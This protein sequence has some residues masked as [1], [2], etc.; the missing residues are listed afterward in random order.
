MKMKKNVQIFVI[1]NHKGGVGKSV[2]SFLAGHLFATDNHEKVRRYEHHRKGSRT[3]VIDLD[4]QANLS[5]AILKEQ[6]DAI[7][8]GVLEAIA[9]QDAKSYIVKSENHENLYVLPAT[10]ALAEFDDIFA[11][12]LADVPNPFHLLE[13]SLE[14]V[15]EEL[16]I[17]NIVIDTSPSL[18]KMMLLGLNVSFGNSTNVLIPFQLDDFGAKSIQQIARTVNS[19]RETTNENINVLGL[20]PVLLEGA[21]K[22]DRETLEQVREVYGDLVFDSKIMRKTDIKTLVE[23]G[24]SETYANERKALTMYYDVVKEMKERV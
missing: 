3:L 17:E 21:S 14:D 8:G 15:V 12:S 9:D 18:N 2:L 23:S 19:V 11:K 6:Y 1:T 22:R 5:T 13:T 7:N 4:F 16:G 10:S 24:F 20:L